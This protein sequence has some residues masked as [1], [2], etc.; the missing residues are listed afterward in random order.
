ME[1]NPLASHAQEIKQNIQFDYKRND[2][3]FLVGIEIEGCLLND[4]GRP[5]DASALI[6]KSLNTKHPLDNEYGKCQFEFKTY[7]LSFYEL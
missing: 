5:I 1:Q 2:P 4:K 3:V 6:E 7:P